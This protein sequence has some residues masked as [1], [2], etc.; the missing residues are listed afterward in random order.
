MAQAKK[1]LS[2]AHVRQEN[3]SEPRRTS[4]PR[5]KSSMGSAHGSYR[6]ETEATPT[7][8]RIKG[9]EIVI[10]WTG[11]AEDTSSKTKSWKF[12][13]DI[14]TPIAR[15][16]DD[17]TLQLIDT[18]HRQYYFRS[19]IELRTPNSEHLFGY[20]EIQHLSNRKST[21]WL[22]IPNNRTDTPAV[23]LVRAHP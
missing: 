14:T 5:Y 10:W 18:R 9:Q 12:F 4:F 19:G 16:R 11:R 23:L 22:P 13:L 15:R 7:R 20:L 8:N 21:Y 1:S 2:S 3:R 6:L 17:R